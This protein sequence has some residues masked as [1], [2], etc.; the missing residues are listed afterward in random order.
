MFNQVV[1][2]QKT[3]NTTINILAEFC[4]FVFTT[5]QQFVKQSAAVGVA[6]LVERLL[7]SR[8]SA[9]KLFGMR[10][11]KLEN[12]PLHRWPSINVEQFETDFDRLGAHNFV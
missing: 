1:Y 11:Y 5:S 7:V 3:Y 9:L 2:S 12:V 8:R 10:E 4:N 6:L